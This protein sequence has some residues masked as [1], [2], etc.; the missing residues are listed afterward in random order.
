MPEV[1]SAVRERGIIFGPESIGAILG[2]RKTQTRRVAHFESYDGGALNLAAS[3]L[4]PA[5]YHTGMPSSGFVLSSRDDSGCWN[6]RTKPVRSPYGLPGD[7]LWVRETFSTDSSRFYPFAPV[8]YAQRDGHELLARMA[9][10]CRYQKPLDARVNR[11][12]TECSCDFRW[13]SPLLMPRR[14]SRVT[15]E[16]TAVRLERLLALTDADAI[17]EGC[18]QGPA[19]DAPRDWYRK[20]WD[21]LNGDRG[22]PWESN[23][24][25]WVVSFK[26]LEGSRP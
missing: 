24:W 16:V 19:V 13:R 20:G 10:D 17:A 14:L 6:D 5:H 2:G 9:A 11:P 18:P 21:A 25:I 4:V 26:L 7:R 15:L 12:H 8:V 1:A 23:P 22:F 3:S